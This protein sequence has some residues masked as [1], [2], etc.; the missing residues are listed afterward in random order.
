[1][2]EGTCRQ[3]PGCGGFNI[4]GKKKKCYFRKSVNA[5]EALADDD[6]D[7]YEK[8]DASTIE[9][10]EESEASEPTN[11]SNSSEQLSDTT[12]PAV[13]ENSQ[14]TAVVCAGAESI[15]QCSKASIAD[16]ENNVSAPTRYLSLPY[17]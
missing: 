16:M 10:I 9:L 6:R 8:V 1:M 15:R 4:V 7:C 17:E 3:H 14:Q 13:L 5:C 12:Q 11:S 2:C